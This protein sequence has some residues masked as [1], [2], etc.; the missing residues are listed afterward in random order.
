MYNNKRFLAIIPA[1][2]G[3]KGLTDKNIKSLNGKPVLSY[4]IE[5]AKKSGIFDNIVVSTDSE[6]Y[7]DIAKKYGAN[8]PFMRPPF[9]ATDTST[10]NEVLEYTITKLKEIEQEYDYFMLLQPTSPLRT[11]EDI[12]ESTKLL[13]TK[14]ANTIVSVCEVDHSPL[15]TNV[16]NESLSLENFLSKDVITRRQDLQ[17]YYRL[18]GSIY[19]SQV[20]YF[21]K[22]KYFYGERSYAYIMD[23]KRSIDIDDEF[24]FLVAETIMRAMN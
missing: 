9:L 13:F 5:V 8:I 22:Y 18:N 10:T 15:Y 19:I 1:R 12:L 16:L 4:T 21:L 7:A 2:S 3:S 11:V 20:N 17:K 6:E 14:N 23:K 24:D